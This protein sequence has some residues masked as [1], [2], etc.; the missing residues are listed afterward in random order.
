M[1][2]IIQYFEIQPFIVTL[3]GMFLARGLCYAITRRRRSRSPTRRTSRLAQRSF[4]LPGDLFVTAR[5][6]RWRSSSSRSP[7]TSC[8]TP[9]S[10]ATSMPIGGN[11]QSALLMGLPGGAD[12]DAGLHDQRLLL[13]PRRHPV[14]L[15]HALRL[16]QPRGRHGARRHR[17]GRHRRHAADR[18][19]RLPGRARCSACWCSASSRR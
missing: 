2:C 15:L 11:E 5:R 8:T 1:G 6:H 9:A 4:T 12:E 18:R 16:R 17:R 7:S 10:A 14:L 19:H 3:A 13:R